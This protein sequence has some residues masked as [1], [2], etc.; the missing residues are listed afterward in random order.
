M[1]DVLVQSGDMTTT[2]LAPGDGC[3]KVMAKTKMDKVSAGGLLQVLVKLVNPNPNP[4]AAPLRYVL[5]LTLPQGVTLASVQSL[6]SITTEPI[7]AGSLVVVG[8][9]PIPAGKKKILV[10]FDL[11]VGAC[12]KSPIVFPPIV[13]FKVDN[14]AVTCTTR[15]TLPS[16]I[17]YNDK[18]IAA[19]DSG[20]CS[21]ITAAHEIDVPKFKLYGG[22]AGLRCVENGTPTSPLV[23][24]TAD[25]CFE[26]C[27]LSVARLPLF[28][29]YLQGPQG[30]ECRCIKGTCTLMPI[31]LLGRRRTRSRKLFRASLMER[32]KGALRALDEDTLGAY[33]VN[34]LATLAPTPRPT[35]R[36]TVRGD[37]C[38]QMGT[39]SNTMSSVLPFCSAFPIVFVRNNSLRQ[40][41]PRRPLRRQ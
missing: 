38:I 5:Q 8:L 15:P 32:N 2:A 25:A 19:P 7:V 30:P 9:N 3:L 39:L 21:T 12:A 36:P 33:Q 20:A 34:V 4:K 41:C 31:A 40:L 11:A 6:P 18:K 10:K 22:V 37:G 35:T 26:S 16:V 24:P 27:S 1:D 14:G 29:N 23:Q 17:I 28:F 13:S